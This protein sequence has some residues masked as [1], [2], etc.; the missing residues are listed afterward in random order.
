[1]LF[2]IID[3]KIL[4]ILLYGSEL[5]FN[6]PLP[7]MEIVHNKEKKKYIYMCV[8]GFPT[9]PRFLPRPKHFIVNCEQSVVKFAE[10]WRKMNRKTQFLYQIF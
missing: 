1:M 3:C 7:D 10:K 6:H 5:W 8:S 4:P 9:L 2:K